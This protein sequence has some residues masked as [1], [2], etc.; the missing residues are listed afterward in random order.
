MKRN[1]TTFA[2]LLCTVPRKPLQ[3]GAKEQTNMR[4]AYIQ[5]NKIW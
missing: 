2:A 4:K 3:E 1:I 5:E